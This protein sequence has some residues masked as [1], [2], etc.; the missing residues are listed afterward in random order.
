[1][2]S[3]KIFILT[4]KYCEQD[5]DSTENSSAWAEAYKESVPAKKKKKNTI[6]GGLHN[7]EVAI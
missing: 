1:M 5:F 2:S 7:Q 6:L 4:N 3:G